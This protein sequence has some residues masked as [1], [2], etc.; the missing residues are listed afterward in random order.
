MP[1]GTSTQKNV[2]VVLVQPDRAVVEAVDAALQKVGASA[3]MV[4]DPRN[5][6]M[7]LPRMTSPQRLAELQQSGRWQIA[8]T[9]PGLS[10]AVVRADGV[11]GNPLTHRIVSNGEQES[12]TAMAER[13]T[14]ILSAVAGSVG[15][16][17]AP[18]FYY[19]GGDYGQLSLDTDPAAIAALS[20]AVSRS[21]AAALC[22][23]DNGFISGTPDMLRLPAKAVPPGWGAAALESHILEGNPVV[24]ARLELA[25]LYYWHGQSEVATYWFRKAAEAGANPFEVTFNLGA[26]AAIQGDLAF[27]LEMA[28][29]A[30]KLAPVDETRAVRL[31]EKVTDM[32]RPTARLE[33]L[34]WWD[35]E[36]RSYWEAGA[37][38]EGPV[39][40]WLRWEA[41]MKRHN[42]EQDGVGE[43]TASSV[44]LG[45]LAYVAPEVWVEAGFQEWMMDSLPDETG[46]RARLRLPNSW[47]KGYVNLISRMEMMETVEALRE[48]ITSHREGV[49]TYSRLMHFWDCFADL[50]L[51]QRSDGNDTLWGNVRLIRRI[52][53]T[54]YLGVGYAGRYADSTADAPE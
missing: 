50:S 43:E 39:K 25:K 38:A 45:F 27:A 17:K 33:A 22:R 47:L 52:K 32:R 6:K 15:S 37:G 48:G 40:D 9:C 12:Q 2:M 1:D 7:A 10:P 46:W 49:E 19:P 54:P 51:T 18:L 28:R 42:W 35:N 5:L 21:F 23:D 44:D 53:E 16:G 26:N 36:D 41:G 29:E 8:L 11:K 13:V 34:A 14:G 20:N 31:L 4:V 30:V 24:R 3:V